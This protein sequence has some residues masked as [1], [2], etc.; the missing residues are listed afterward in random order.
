MTTEEKIKRLNI[1]NIIW[2][3]YSFI[4]LFSIYSVELQKN[5]I[6]NKDFKSKLKARNINISISIIVFFIYIYFLEINYK[7]F[8]NVS[9]SSVN[10]NDYKIYFI[11]LVGSIL[12][13]IGGIIN[14]YVNINSNISEEEISII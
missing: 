7:D 5:Y 12:F 6:S 14:I 11:N 2:I 13:L 3:I 8:K 9:N 4:V 10:N 1:E